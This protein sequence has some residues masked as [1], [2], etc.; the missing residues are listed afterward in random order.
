MFRDLEKRMHAMPEELIAS[1]QRGEN[2][3]RSEINDFNAL[4]RQVYQ[5]PR[6]AEREDVLTQ[7]KRYF[8]EI[9]DEINLPLGV[10]FST[11][12]HAVQE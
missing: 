6:I 7:V 3:Q 2:L 8:A 10:E 9:A 12:A 4:R 5:L 11:L 1:Q